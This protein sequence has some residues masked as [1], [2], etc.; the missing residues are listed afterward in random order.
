MNIIVTGASRGIGFEIVKGFAG[1]PGNR[2]IALSRN[3]KNLEK[4]KNVCQSTPSGIGVEIMQA[5]LSDTAHMTTWLIPRIQQFFTKLDILIN[6]A[7]YLVNKPFENIQPEELEN[8]ININ[9]KVPFLFIQALI[10]LLKNADNPHI[11]NIS[12]MGGINGSVKFPGLTAYSAAKGGLGILTE[13]LA[14]EYRDSGISFNCLALG[15]V[16]TEMFE[17]AFPGSKA[18]L[19]TEEMALFIVDFALNGHKIFNGKILP[20]SISTP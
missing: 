11:L 10:G 18:P 7:G 16:Q 8:T 14:E 9:L 6:N 13:C 2:I 1:K 15:A 4:L 3:K 20:V 17:E 12:S 19:T 5:D